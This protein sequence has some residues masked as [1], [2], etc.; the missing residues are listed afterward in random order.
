MITER[1]TVRT[2]VAQWL[3]KIAMVARSEKA[4]G[5]EE[6]VIET[7][8][9][10]L[11]MCASQGAAPADKMRALL[12]RGDFERKAQKY[13][14][15][16]AILLLGIQK[17][18]ESAREAHTRE[19][20]EVATHMLRVLRETAPVIISLRPEALVRV[21]DAVNMTLRSFP[22]AEGPSER[23]R[24]TR[25]QEIFGGDAPSILLREVMGLPGD[26]DATLSVTD[27]DVAFNAGLALRALGAEVAP[28]AFAAI[29]REDPAA[30]APED[31]MTP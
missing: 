15:T 2:N 14:A 7:S 27:A 21:T 4:G 17:G 28:E 31:T 10:I 30:E 1:T 19:C 29:G 25:A 9:P 5:T 26:E 16:N 8:E 12:E 13:L 11:Y 18:G 3:N 22:M 23:S 20:E 24:I 6:M